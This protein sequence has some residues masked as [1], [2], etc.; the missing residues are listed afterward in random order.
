MRTH[1][2]HKL[3]IRWEVLRSHPQRIHKIIQHI[4]II[5]ILNLIN[6][7]HNVIVQLQLP[8]LLNKPHKRLRM[9]SLKRL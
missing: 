6:I 2:H 9:V 8:Q 5:S 3:Q 4:S 7:H 1:R